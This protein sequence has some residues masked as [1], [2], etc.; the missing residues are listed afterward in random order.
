MALD[1]KEVEAEFA[2]LNGRFEEGE[3]GLLELA[4]DRR[5]SDGELECLRREWDGRAFVITAPLRQHSDGTL[6]VC[7]QV[8]VI[9]LPLVVLALG[10]LP[11]GLLAWKL[12][13]VP[14]EEWMRTLKGIALPLGALAVGGVVMMASGGR[15][16]GLLAGG[17]LMAGGGYLAYR[18]LAPVPPP[19]VSELEALRYHEGVQQPEL[20]VE[21]A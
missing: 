21:V 7:F 16:P 6:S 9:W 19:P 15:W 12:W 1:L 20:S 10:A 3:W 4:L 5:L 18:E 2:R 17:A 11:I 14:A 8:G 13:K